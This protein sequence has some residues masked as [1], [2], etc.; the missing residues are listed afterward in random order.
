MWTLQNPLRSFR[1]QLHRLRPLKKGKQL[2]KRHRSRL[3]DGKRH[4]SHYHQTVVV[5]Q[6]WHSIAIVR[7]AVQLDVPLFQGYV[8]KDFTSLSVHHDDLFFIYVKFHIV[9]RSR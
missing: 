3:D 2:V 9:D 7:V 4:K 6:K 8:F 5:N 1:L